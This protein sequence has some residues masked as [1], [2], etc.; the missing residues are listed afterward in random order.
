M[1]V[2]SIT[3]YSYPSA[4]IN[5]T[6]VGGWSHLKRVVKKWRKPQNQSD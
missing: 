1:K 6:G 2:Q 5:F 3:K 4:Q